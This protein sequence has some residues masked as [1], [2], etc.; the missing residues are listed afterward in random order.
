MSKESAYE[1]MEIWN[2]DAISDVRD[3][4]WFLCEEYKVITNCSYLIKGKLD[5]LDIVQIRSFPIKL[6]I[7]QLCSCGPYFDAKISDLKQ[8]HP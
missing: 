3:C 7:L 5:L 2:T 8:N 4:Q 1:M 6:G